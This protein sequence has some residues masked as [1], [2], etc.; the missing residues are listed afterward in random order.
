MPLRRAL[1]VAHR[2]LHA[3]TA[4]ACPR[5]RQRARPSGALLG[6]RAATGGR[7]MSEPLLKV[8]GLRKFFTMKKGFPNPTVLTV[9]AVDGVS[10]HVARGEVF[11][12]V[13]ESGCGKSTVG[14]A[15]LRLVEPDDG[16]VTFDGEDITAASKAR[17][18]SLRRQ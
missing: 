9:R 10:F 1:P 16:A 15:L 13:G 7:G 8:E 12:I 18:K 17:M 4:A 14:R 6:A 2:A 5:R 11:G 3:G